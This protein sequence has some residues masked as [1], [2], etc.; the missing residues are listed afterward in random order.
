MATILSL[1]AKRVIGSRATFNSEHCAKHKH[2]INVKSR[3]DGLELMKIDFMKR[4]VKK[5]S[6][7]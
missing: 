7:M 1:F 6:K 5:F 4:I 2:K 3:G